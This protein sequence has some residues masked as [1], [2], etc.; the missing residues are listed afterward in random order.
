MSAQIVVHCIQHSERVRALSVADWAAARGIDLRII[1]VDRGEPLPAA[2]LVQRL[3]VL[4]G[5]MMTDEVDEHPWLVLEREWLRA[6]VEHGE[7]KVLGICLGSQLLAEALGGSVERA[8]VP[9]VGWQ[10]IVRT[11]AGDDH[12][13]LAALPREFDAMQWHYDAW[14]LPPGAAL[15]ATSDGCATQAFTYGEDVLAVQFHPEFTFDRTR[16]LVDSTTDDLTPRGHVQSPDQFLADPERFARLR[17]LCFDLLDRALDVQVAA[18]I[19]S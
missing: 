19:S 7:A 1:R 18:P 4:G 14:T 10:R 13:V 3:V 17:E 8:E 15:A 12:P 6:V 5:A 9:E 11:E 2:P 16:E